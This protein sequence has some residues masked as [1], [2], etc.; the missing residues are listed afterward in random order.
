MDFEVYCDE[1]RP[2]L[3]SSKKSKYRY[4]MIGSLWIPA[5]QRNFF[6]NEIE[7]LKNEFGFRGE[8][9]W[10]K[11]SDTN[12]DYY[13]AL[14]DFFVEQKLDMRFRCIA[15][16]KT[17]FN[18]SWHNNDNE[19][20]FY[21]FY[22]QLLHQWILDF[23]TYSIF[24]DIKTNRDSRRLITLKR[25]LSSSNL[26]S[27]I[28]NVQALPSKQVALIQMTDLLLGIAGFRMNKSFEGSLSKK[29]LVEHFE[30][31]I[32]KKK[33]VPTDKNEDKFN[34]FRINLQG[35]W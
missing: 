31:R 27:D 30:N 29:Q 23:N 10:R 15:I 6:K 20:G 28:I 17:L 25:C 7:S 34:I 16:D 11:V 9:K 22:Y 8:I 2:D 14:I 35:G 4:L 32:N 21:K 5:S 12:I 26:S 18:N 24:C 13:K 3:F 19:L 1:S 33:L